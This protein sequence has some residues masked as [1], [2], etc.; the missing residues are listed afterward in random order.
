[1]NFYSNANKTHFH[2]KGFA[3]TL[4][5]KEILLHWEMTYSKYELSCKGVTYRLTNC[6]G[7]MF[8][9]TNFLHKDSRISRAVCLKGILEFC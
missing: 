4:I 1:M 3:L 5:L 7:T 8:L 6:I 2:K 9:Q